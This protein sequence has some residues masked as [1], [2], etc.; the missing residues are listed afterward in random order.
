MKR[1]LC[2]VL[3][4]LGVGFFTQEKQEFP[5]IGEVSAQR[6]NVRIKPSVD[7]TSTIV[8]VLKMGTQ[9]KV[10]AQEND[11]LQIAA[12][13]GTYCWVFAELVKPSQEK[14]FG[15]IGSSEAI[16][17]SDC[18]ITAPELGR[19]KSGQKVKILGEKYGWYRIQAPP[20]VR[21]WVAKKYI[22][23]VK[24]LKPPKPPVKVRIDLPKELSRIDKLIEK[25][26]SKLEEGKHMQIDFSR[27]VR[28]LRVLLAKV[29]KD[30][31]MRK[32]VGERLKRVE[33]YNRLVR[34]FREGVI[35]TRRELQRKLDELMGKLKPKEYLFQGYVD[36]TGAFLIDRP[37]KHKLI[38]GDGKIICF[39]KS[40]DK[41]MERLLD[42]Y[43]EKF[44]GINGE[45]KTI[46]SGYW[47]GYRIVI[48]REVDLIIKKKK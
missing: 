16:L 31:K 36:S 29:R 2:I 18:R 17:R 8:G 9:V 43:R 24:P 47:R 37:A 38:T 19:L 6:L 5:Y 33:D 4:I 35:K 28:E 39:L 32:I 22:K 30:P 11:F 1:A 41:K 25:E 40:K 34:K 44:V 26:L 46:K 21:L 12:P 13:E 23:Y 10:Y 27:A 20:S 15:I 3:V 14:G 7:E 48:L 45:L 42:R